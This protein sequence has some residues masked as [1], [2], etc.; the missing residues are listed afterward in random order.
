MHWSCPA[1]KACTHLLSFIRRWM[2][3]FQA[4]TRDRNGHVC[5]QAWQF[6]LLFTGQFSRENRR[7]INVCMSYAVNIITVCIDV[8]C[9]Q[10]LK[11]C[12]QITL[13]YDCVH[14][15]LSYDCVHPIC[16]KIVHLPGLNYHLC[17]CSFI[18]HRDSA[19]FLSGSMPTVN[20]QIIVSRPAVDI[21][22]RGQ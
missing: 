6:I 12:S 17:L 19:S 2:I 8:C 13:S 21:G 4:S 15:T 5:T 3:W 18:F 9:L 7:Y 11:I 10:N 22:L 16:L 20:T 14:L 1:C